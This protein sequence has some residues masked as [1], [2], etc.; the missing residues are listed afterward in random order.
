MLLTS[1]PC[2]ERPPE[3]GSAPGAATP[4]TRAP[5]ARAGGLSGC[6]PVANV[7]VLKI[8]DSTAGAQAAVLDRHNGPGAERSRTPDRGPPATSTLAWNDHTGMSPQWTVTSDACTGFP[9]FTWC[10]VVTASD[11]SPST[12]RSASRRTTPGVYGDAK[13]RA[14]G[15]PWRAGGLFR[16]QSV[17]RGSANCGLSSRPF[18]SSG[19]RVAGSAATMSTRTEYELPCRQSPPIASGATGEAAKASTARP[20]GLTVASAVVEDT[21]HHHPQAHSRH[22][23]RARTLG[24]QS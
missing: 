17:S 10:A 13:S 22:A 11:Q 23:D 3:R 19:G 5:Q 8:D 14:A 7:A 1:I 16:V 18:G 2:V 24:D 6:P 4:P 12:A 15:L 9:G 21:P 20:S